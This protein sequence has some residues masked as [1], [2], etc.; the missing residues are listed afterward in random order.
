MLTYLTRKPK[1]TSAAQ[2]E[3][4]SLVQHSSD[5]YERL[6]GRAHGGHHYLIYVLKH[7][8]MLEES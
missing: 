1:S 5:K 2:A 4:V 6:Q 8:A 3:A 7:K